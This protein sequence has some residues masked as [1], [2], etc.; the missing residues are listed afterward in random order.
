VAQTLVCGPA[1]RTIIENFDVEFAGLHK[2]SCRLIESTPAE[3]L[4]HA[5]CASTPALAAAQSVGEYV[6]RSA[7]VVEQTFGGIT[8]NLWDDPFEWTLPE[9]LSTRRRVI[10]YLGEVEETRQR[11]FASFRTDGD[12]LK[13][14]ATPSDNM[15]PIISLLLDTLV[16]AQSYQGRAMFITETLSLT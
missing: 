3:L 5:A 1:E 12:L 10:E 2:R 16:R 8:S 6:L 13:K 7:G 15:R 4:Y 14:V 9:T 11:A